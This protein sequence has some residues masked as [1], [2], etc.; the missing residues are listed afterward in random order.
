MLRKPQGRWWPFYIIACSDLGTTNKRRKRDG[1]IAL[2][3]TVTFRHQWDRP[4]SS[5]PMIP[6][7]LI[8]LIKLESLRRPPEWD[9]KRWRSHPFGSIPSWIKIF[10]AWLTRTESAIGWL[11]PIKTKLTSHRIMVSTKMKRER[12]EEEEI[13]SKSLQFLV[14][15]W[16]SVSIT[17]RFSFRIQSRDSSH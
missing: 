15:T 12:K 10:F 14:T 8:L 3:S 6:G 4:W 11:R 2:Y 16:I 13:E 5:R 7:L 1:I 9:I 17:F